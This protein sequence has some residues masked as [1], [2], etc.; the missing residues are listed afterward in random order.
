[1]ED[2]N[3]IEYLTNKQLFNL[4]PSENASLDDWRKWAL[5][6]SDRYARMLEIEQERRKSLH[7]MGTEIK[8][9]NKALNRYK[10][11]IALFEKGIEP[12]GMTFWDLIG[13]LIK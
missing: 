12:T 11:E 5:Q 6:L 3:K 9:K 1:M 8:R 4:K 13:S 10:K 7:S 2:E